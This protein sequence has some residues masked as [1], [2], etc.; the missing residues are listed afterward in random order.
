MRRGFPWR[1]LILAAVAVVAIASALTAYTVRRMT[2]A[3]L[4]VNVTREFRESLPSVGP[5]NGILETATCSVPETFTQTDSATLFNVLPLGTNVAEIRVPAVYRYHV[6]I[7]DPW[8]LEIHGAVCVV[9]APQIRASL[10]PAIVTGQMEKSTSAGWLRFDAAQDLDN[11]EKGITAELDKRAGDAA[12]IAY[13]REAS[14]QAVAAFVKAWLL[15]ENSWKDDQFH[16]VVVLFPDDPVMIS[17]PAS[18]A[19]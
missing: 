1:L 8:S 14:R 19:H 12:H 2:A 10:P 5:S 13:V 18:P 11:L 7:F 16:Q 9:R 15:K 3:P 6:Q 17:A 4:A